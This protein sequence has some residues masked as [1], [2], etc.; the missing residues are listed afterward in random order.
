MVGTSARPTT[1]CLQVS[2]RLR[3]H[4][5]LSDAEVDV[6]VLIDER[7]RVW[8]GPVAERPLQGVT[9]AA[10]DLPTFW[11]GAPTVGRW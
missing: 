8:C 4:S 7:F 10:L 3:E 1:A 11:H 9:A 6:V 2:L 5:M